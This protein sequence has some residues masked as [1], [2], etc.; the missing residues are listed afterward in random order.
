MSLMYYWR[1]LRILRSQNTKSIQLSPHSIIHSLYQLLLLDYDGTL[2]DTREAIKHSMRRTFQLLGYPPPT[3]ALMDEAVGRGLVL[4]DM[5]LWLHP[6]GTPPL[7]AVWVDTYRMVYNTES[8]ALAT[9]FLGAEQ[10][11][12]TAAAHNQAVVVISNKG[13]DILENS[14]R[15]LGLRD[16]I[17]LVLGDSPSRVLPLK[18]DPA[19]FTQVV[20]AHFPHVSLAAIL[21]VGDTATDLLFARNSGIAACWASYGFGQEADCLPLHPTHRIDNLLELLPLL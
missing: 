2:C 14:L 15:R 12:A 5:L 1:R 8:E 11:L 16:Q 18:P 4:P 21:M 7:P 13:L 6:P 20:Q 10:V 17:A 3:E 9:L 19:L